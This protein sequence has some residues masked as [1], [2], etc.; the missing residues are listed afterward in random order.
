[1]AKTYNGR[2]KSPEEPKSGTFWLVAALGS[3]A[4]FGALGPLALP[5]CVGCFTAYGKRAKE[6]R[7]YRRFHEF[8]AV[9][10]MRER[11]LLKEL[12]KISDMTKGEVR[13][14]LQ[15]MIGRG[16]FGEDA[17]LDVSRDELV[18][19]P[20]PRP[21]P[22]RSQGGGWRDLVFDLLSALKGEKAFSEPVQD[23]EY[24]RV[25]PKAQKKP[26]AESAP[27]A[28]EAQ[29][30]RP[31]PPK[32]NARKTYMEELERTLNE[33]YQLNQQIEDE[34]VSERIDRIGALT[35]GIFRAVIEKPEREQDVRKFMNYYLPTTLKLLKSY[36]MLENQSYQGENIVASR[37]KI[38]SVLDML[39]AAYE[40]QLDRLFGNDALDIATDIDVLETMMA[41]D[42]LTEKG[43]LRMG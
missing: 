23:A 18:L 11:V 30:E 9:I 2:F 15:Q 40:K 6:K 32:P 25:E 16:Y 38:E 14:I 3:V 43:Q 12:A 36:D 35:G 28:E 1:M 34:A 20:P 27:K 31:E 21:E 7:L 13:S 39:I 19:P 22:A 41:G 17:Y 24:V 42:G 10:G 26:E 37:R 8:C 33:L 5:I 4:L 29:A